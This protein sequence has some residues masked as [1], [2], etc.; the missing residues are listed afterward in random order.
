M[1]TLVKN[2]WS[3]EEIGILKKYYPEGGYA[4]CADKGLLRSMDSMHYKARDLNLMHNNHYTKDKEWSNSDLELLKKYYPEGGVMLCIEKGL[5]FPITV[6][7]YKARVLGLKIGKGKAKR[8]TMWSDSDI[9]LLKKYYPVGGTSLCKEK[10]LNKTDSSIYL[11][12]HAMGLSR[13]LWYDKDLEILRKYYPEGGHR[14]C[15]EKG[16]KF[17]TSS[18]QKQAEIEGLVYRLGFNWTPEED[19]ILKEY[20]PIG[21]YRLCIEKGLDATRSSSAVYTRACILKLK[22]IKKSDR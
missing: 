7:Q 4:L 10:G 22:Y 11:K 9:E 2:R 19:A 1:N 12:A 5:T 3:E 20:Y 16:L 8:K 6:I 15:K 14:L 13:V 18:I 21:G 17:S